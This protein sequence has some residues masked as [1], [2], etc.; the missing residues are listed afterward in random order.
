VQRRSRYHGKGTSDD[1]ANGFSGGAPSS[2]KAGVAA[3]L[4][5]LGTVSNLQA[6]QGSR[7]LVHQGRTF[8]SMGDEVV[9][10]EARSGNKLWTRKVPGNLARAGGHLAAPPALAGGQLFVATLRGAILQIDP[11]TG[12]IVKSY[13]VGHPV[14][15]QPVIHNGW[16]YVGTEN[17]RL[18]AIDTQDRRLTGWTQWGGD[19]ARS[20]VR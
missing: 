10:S 8:A 18:V 1:A 11:K 9:A 20:G 13:R 7:L 15:S 19:A 14:R 17:G 6:Y 3:K 5:G 2:A 4:V 12:N 16:I